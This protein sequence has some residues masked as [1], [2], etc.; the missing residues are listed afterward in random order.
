MIEV[1]LAQAAVGCL[2]TKATEGAVQTLGVDAYK[3]ALE[4]LKGFFSYKFAGRSELNEVQTN[5][6]SLTS[7]VAEQV[8]ND[9][10]FKNELE[11]LVNALQKLSDGKNSTGTSYTN[12]DAIADIDINSVSGSNVAGRDAIAGNQLSGG[13][14]HIGGDQRGSTFR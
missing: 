9:T 11:N 2:V 14:N 8:A 3:A 10:A 6:S 4:K 1:A 5:P 13:Q 7:L 12:V